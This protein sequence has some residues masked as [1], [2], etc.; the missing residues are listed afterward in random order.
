[1]SLR[2]YLLRNAFLRNKPVF[3][4][5]QFAELHRVQQKTIALVDRSTNS[6]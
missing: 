4:V 2:V 6:R 1:M 5:L 3:V